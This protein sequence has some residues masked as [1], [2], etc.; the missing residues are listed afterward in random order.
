M[1]TRPWDHLNAGMDTGIPAKVRGD[2]QLSGWHEASGKNSV[3]C[4]FKPLAW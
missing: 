2:D 4:R 3:L 1:F